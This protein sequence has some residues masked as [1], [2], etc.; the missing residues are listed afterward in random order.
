MVIAWRNLDLA[1]PRKCL[2]LTFVE[3]FQIAKFNQKYLFLLKDRF[4]N[5]KNQLS[6]R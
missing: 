5:R 3:D 6:I 2:F 1:Q 4:E